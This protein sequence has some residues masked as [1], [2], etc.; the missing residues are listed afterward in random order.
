MPKILSL[1]ILFLL[2]ISFSIQGQTK[3]YVDENMQEIDSINF[4]KKCDARVFKCLTYNTDSLI[5]NKV[6]N[7]F[8]FGKVSPEEY[9][10][11]RMLL[12]K[13][14][15]IEIPQNQTLI[16]KN[17]D[18]IGGSYYHYV[19]KM[20]ESKVEKPFWRATPISL[21]G[22][23]IKVRIPRTKIMSEETYEKYFL[24]SLK[25]YIKCTKKIER[26]FNLPAYTTYSYNGF[27][28]SKYKDVTWIENP[29]I[30]KTKFLNQIYKASFI[31]L[32]PNGEYFISSSKLMFY[33]IQTLLKDNDW[34][35]HKKD[36][37]VSRLNNLRNGRGI[38]EASRTF[39]SG[40]LYCF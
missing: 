37:E 20:E 19:K 27:K 30:I 39:N 3:V 18:T 36:L 11:I 16:I 38:F 7:R 23:A 12:M 14:G 28:K 4:Y 13:S 29:S 9:N 10:Q 15:E 6:H 22:K 8:K 2:L 24:G 5:V 32:K 17:I 21:N 31:I 40:S 25:K 33:N 35:E 26:K 1:K 34:K